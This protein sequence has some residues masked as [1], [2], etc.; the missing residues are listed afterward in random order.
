MQVSQTFYQTRLK[1]RQTASLTA[2]LTVCVD[3]GFIPPAGSYASADL[4]I[5]VKYITDASA[6]V[7]YGATGKSCDYVQGPDTSTTADN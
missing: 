4:V 1:V 2:P 7:S 5:Y 6:A 3:P